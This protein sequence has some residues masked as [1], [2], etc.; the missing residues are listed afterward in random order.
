M[1]G[2]VWVFIY[3]WA[4]LQFYSFDLFHSGAQVFLWK[5]TNNSLFCCNSRHKHTHIEKQ[6]KELEK[7]VVEMLH[8]E[9]Y[10]S[11]LSF[12]IY[13]APHRFPS[14]RFS[15]CS[16]SSLLFCCRCFCCCSFPPF[17]LG[18]FI[19]FSIHIKSSCSNLYT[20]RMKKE[21]EKEKRTRSGGKVVK[22]AVAAAAC[23]EKWRMWELDSLSDVRN[24]LVSNRHCRCMLGQIVRV[25]DELCRWSHRTNN[26][27]NVRMAKDIW[28]WYIEHRSLSYGTRLV[29]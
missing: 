1:I 27:R 19:F 12:T 26:F 20:K 13:D 16:L 21:N 23:E 5:V 7:N 8:N 2:Y 4:R 29:G 22:P 6:K 10:I 14:K 28:L 17:R 3:D 9:K 25:S 15:S 18:V 11:F 24:V